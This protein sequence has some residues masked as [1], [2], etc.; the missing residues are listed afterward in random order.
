M[1]FPREHAPGNGYDTLISGQGLPTLGA[2]KQ[3][4]RRRTGGLSRERWSVDFHGKH[5]LVTGATGFI[6]S[7]LAR[8]LADQGA[9]LRLLVRRTSSLRWIEDV[10]HC[11]VT[12]DLARGDDLTEALEGV[13]LVLHLAGVLRATQRSAYLLGNVEGTRRLLQAAGKSPSPPKVVILSSLAAAGPSPS[14]KPLQEDD[15]PRPVGLYGMSKLM[16]EEVALKMGDRLDT[17]ILRPPMV[18]GPREADFLGACR[19]VRWGLL[20]HLGRERR[21]FSVILASD[22]VVAIM[23]A[24]LR[25][26]PGRTYFVS[27]SEVLSWSDLLSG[28]ATT[29]GV[30]GR[31]IVIPERILPLLARWGEIAARVTGKE[32]LM[33]R[34]RTLEW[35]HRHWVCDASRA[36]QEWGFRAR[37]PFS[38][39][40]RKTVEWYRQVGWL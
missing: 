29:L 20:P 10:P 1:R 19:A 39:G 23:E 33:N 9:R 21:T 35:R 31:R 22:L 16:A 6:G 40:I 30:R 34:E 17:V 18:Y 36:G 27:S 13:D 7:H 12:A 4:D 24:A 26:P 14:G 38:L 25:A 8:S 3:G 2:G 11:R 5:V 32:S 28:I 15:P 37:T